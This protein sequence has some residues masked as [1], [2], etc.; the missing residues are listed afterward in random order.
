VSRRGRP[1]IRDVQRNFFPRS[2]FVITP[3]G[4]LPLRPAPRQV[5]NVGIATNDHQGLSV[6]RQLPGH[7]HQGRCK[8]HPELAHYVLPGRLPVLNP[9]LTASPAI[10]GPTGTCRKMPSAATIEKDGIDLG[11]HQTVLLKRSKSLPST[12]FNRTK[13]PKIR[14]KH[15][16]GK[17][18]DI[19]A[20][21][22][23]STGWKKYWLKQTAKP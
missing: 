3:L 18:Q 20:L 16:N 17:Y 21:K 7:L 10:S 5:G 2:A 13:Q 9:P 6:G 4:R 1:R 12:S 15:P 14:T 11:L 19:Q 22:T 8:A 23:D